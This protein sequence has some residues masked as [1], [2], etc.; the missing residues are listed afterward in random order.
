[1]SKPA[2]RT[3]E[4]LDIENEANV[5]EGQS[6]MDGAIVTFHLNE[7][8]LSLAELH[9]AREFFSRLI[10]AAQKKGAAA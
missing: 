8:T 3:M 5:G 1:M 6:Y 2:V 7:Q 10:D 4:V 9:A